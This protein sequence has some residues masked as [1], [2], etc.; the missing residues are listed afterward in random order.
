MCPDGNQSASM[1]SSVRTKI[2]LSI[3]FIKCCHPL[4]DSKHCLFYYCIAPTD[5][6]L[7]NDDG[8]HAYSNRMHVHSIPF[9]TVLVCTEQAMKAL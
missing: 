1:A 9:K 3:A 4:N 8:Y 6:T 7:Q 5:I 2:I